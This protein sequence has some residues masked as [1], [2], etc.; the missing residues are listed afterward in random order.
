MSQSQKKLKR[1]FL[2]F[3]NQI[4]RKTQYTEMYVIN[5]NS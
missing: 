2:N 1:K 5:E 3:W 4:N